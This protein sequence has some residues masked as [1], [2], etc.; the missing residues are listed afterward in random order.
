M[1]TYET[2]RLLLKPTD[3]DDAQFVLDLLNSPK[4]IEHIGDRN[5]HTLEDAENYIKVKMIPQL[6]ERGFGNFTVICKE[7]G[8]K[9]G[10]CGIYIREGLDVADIGFAFLEKFE[11]KGFAYEAAQHILNLGITDFGLEKI[12]AITTKTNYSSQK[13]IEK[14]GLKFRKFVHIP[15]DPEELMYYE[16]D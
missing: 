1:K 12:S 13:L 4:W 9:M 11:G 14:L 15:N 2:E 3:L 16:T 7:S 6:E 5:V 10:T 8:E